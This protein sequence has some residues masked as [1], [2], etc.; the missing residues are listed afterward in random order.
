MGQDVVVGVYH[1][2]GA[3]ILEPGSESVIKLGI[4]LPDQLIAEMVRR[5][6][7]EHHMYISSSVTGTGRAVS[8]YYRSEAGK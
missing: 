7:P 5:Y 1:V 6:G 2:G 3:F 4:Q 8:W